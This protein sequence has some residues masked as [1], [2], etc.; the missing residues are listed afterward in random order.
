MAA[1]SAADI[2]D[3]KIDYCPCNRC[4]VARKQGRQEVEARVRELAEKYASE[5]EKDNPQGYGGKLKTSDNSISYWLVSR[6]IWKAL[7]GEQ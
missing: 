6:E 4:T 5:A 3:S 2:P 7:D 1:S